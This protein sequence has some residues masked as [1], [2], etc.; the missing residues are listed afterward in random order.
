MDA[1]SRDVESSSYRNWMVVL[2]LIILVGILFPP[3]ANA[4]P[5]FARKYD[6]SCN[7][8]HTRQPRLNSFGQRFLENGY[9]MPGT[10]DGGTVEKSLFGGPLNGVTLDEISNYLAVRFRADIQQA[11]F[12][13]Q[14]EATDD[15][16]IIVPNIINI[17]FAGTA[18][19]KHQFFPGR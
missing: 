2:V 15:V 7:A 16:D 10:E 13:E 9:Q 14:T 1:F 4:V 8:C 17:F 12:K 3:A 6:V 11:S 18:T 5:A 19:K